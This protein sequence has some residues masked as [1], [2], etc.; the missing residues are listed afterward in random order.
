[1]E[2]ELVLSYSSA[3]LIGLM[4]S[5][6]CLGMCGGIS[7]SL[8]MSLPVGAGYRRRQTLMLLAFNG[9]R[10]ASYVAIATLVALLSTRAADQY[11]SVGPIL[12]SIAG[13]L[14]ILMGLSMGHWWQ[15]IRY[16]ERVGAPVWRRVSPLTQ[17]VMPV[18]RTWKALILGGLW[19]WLP[20]GLVYS[21]LGWAALQP[22]VASAAGTMLFFGLGT[23]PSMLATGYAAGWINK[24]KRQPYF[25]RLAAL[26]LIG[27]GIWT[28]P[29]IHSAH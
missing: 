18:D 26:L 1:M 3:Y 14:L 24:L 17:R 23:L 22:T 27:F 16:I 9:G 21:T 19:G 7:A 4:G 12:R 11:A 28:L 2:S 20:C 25:R 10:I 8:S 5:T 6:H 15:G 13:A 29:F